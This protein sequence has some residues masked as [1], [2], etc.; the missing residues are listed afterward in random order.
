MMRMTPYFSGAAT[1]FTVPS[2]PLYVMTTISAAICES[3][4]RS[5][6][7][8]V[9]RTLA[10]SGKGSVGRGPSHSHCTAG[11]NTPPVALLPLQFALTLPLGPYPYAMHTLALLPSSKQSEPQQ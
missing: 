2:S 10:E 6:T 7:S 9:A 8:G 1:G 3:F 5:A 4:G 11:E